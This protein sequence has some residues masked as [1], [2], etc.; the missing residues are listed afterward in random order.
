MNDQSRIRYADSSKSLDVR[1]IHSWDRGEASPVSGGSGLK[2]YVKNQVWQ[3]FE[4]H[5]DVDRIVMVRAWGPPLFLLR[6][7]ACWFDVTGKQVIAA[8]ASA[9]G[10]GMDGDVPNRRNATEEDANNPGLQKGFE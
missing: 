7:K 10:D 1:L 8:P 4:D 2:D 9:E 3:L 6:M 5:R